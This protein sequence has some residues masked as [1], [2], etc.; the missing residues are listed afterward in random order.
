M[1]YALSLPLQQA[2]FTALGGSA[3]LA[4]FVADRIYDAPP[5]GDDPLSDEGPYL[6]IG[7]EKVEA[8]SSADQGGAAHEIDISVHTQ[9]QGFAEA[10]EIG[11]VVSDIVEG[12]SGPLTRGRIVLARFIA[13]RTKRT[14]QGGGRRV[15]LRFRFLIED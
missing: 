6:T 12:M 7:D 8:W 9:N 2:V 10:K 15:D 14:G 13:A 3:A 11:G 5:H 1:T 4:A